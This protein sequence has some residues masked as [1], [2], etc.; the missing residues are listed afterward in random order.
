[1]LPSVRG[2]LLRGQSG[3]NN[4]Q[5]PHSLP[6]AAWRKL[7]SPTPSRHKAR[8][9]TPPD[10]QAL[11]VATV[12][13]GHA[14]RRAPPLAEMP[15]KS[16]GRRL[17]RLPPTRRPIRASYSESSPVERARRSPR[18]AR[19]LVPGS[20]CELIATRCGA[21]AKKGIALAC[22]ARLCHPVTLGCSI[23]TKP[24][25]IHNHTLQRGEGG[26]PL[27]V[28]QYHP[29]HPAVL[30]PSN[31]PC[32]ISWIGLRGNKNHVLLS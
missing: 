6:S 22:S 17:A 14:M 19:W 20:Y 11:A 26:K 31:S 25:I 23:A 13:P 10:S 28:H 7:P 27:F 5:L 2:Q 21:A 24:I 1:M 18:R 32:T 4:P 16:G 8:A 3:V 9:R 29:H 30:C 15:L 12:S